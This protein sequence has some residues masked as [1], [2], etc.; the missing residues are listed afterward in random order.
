MMEQARQDICHFGQMFFQKNQMQYTGGNLS[1]RQGNLVCIKP[2]GVPWEGMEPKDLWVIDLQGNVVESGTNKPSIEW[3]MHTQI[4]VARPDIHAIVHTHAPYAVTWSVKGHQTLEPI[5]PFFCC[6]NGAVNVAPYEPAGEAIL[7]K[8]AVEAIGAEKFACI[9]QSHGIVACGAN[10][11]D[12]VNLALVVED[13][14]KIACMSTA[15]GGDTFYID[16]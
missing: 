12:A 11:T 15:M 6:N 8:V 9:L 16:M 7:G 1:V 3:P 5:M 13:G 4:Y 2:S 14:A 10:M